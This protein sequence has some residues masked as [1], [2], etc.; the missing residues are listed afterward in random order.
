MGIVR[1]STDLLLGLIKHLE[2]TP[3]FCSLVILFTVRPVNH[4]CPTA[5]CPCSELHPPGVQQVIPLHQNR[6]RVSCS[7]LMHTCCTCSGYVTLP[8][9]TSGRGRLD[10][11]QV[12]LRVPNV[13]LS[14]LQVVLRC[15]SVRVYLCGCVWTC[16]LGVCV[17]TKSVHFTMLLIHASSLLLIQ[18]FVT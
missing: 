6:C 12:L 13:D 18:S 2:E 8:F 5:D 1:I 17:E 3:L 4:L 9:L 10:A 16:G 14:V 11:R 7:V 15:L